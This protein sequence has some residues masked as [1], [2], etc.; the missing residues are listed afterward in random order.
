MLWTISEEHPNV[1]FIES[2]LKEN[3]RERKQKATSIEQT[4]HSKSKNKTIRHIYTS[5]HHNYHTTV[6][7]NVQT[8]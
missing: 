1:Q 6:S 8:S 3:V 2:A 7:K 5:G 4:Q